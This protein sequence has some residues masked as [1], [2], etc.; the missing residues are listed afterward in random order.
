MELTLFLLITSSD[1]KMEIF[2]PPVIF[3]LLT[4]GIK[5]SAKNGNKKINQINSEEEDK[6]HGPIREWTPENGWKTTSYE[7]ALKLN[8]KA[9]SKGKKKKALDNPED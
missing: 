8:K 4:K 6:K 1:K 9:S 5:K 3:I 7:E 2:L